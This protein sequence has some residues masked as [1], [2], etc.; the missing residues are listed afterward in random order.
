M[1]VLLINPP[2]TFY[3]G[4]EQPAGNLPIGLMYIAAVLQRA[5]VEVEILDAFIAGTFQKNGDAISVG[6]PFEQIKQEI[7]ARKPDIVGISGPFT[8]QIENSIKVSNLAKEVNP[9]I[10]TVMGGPHV[11]LVPKEFL[12]EAKN[13]DIAVIGEGEYAMLDIVQAFEGKKQLSRIQG[14]AYR[15]NEK[16]LVNPTRPL[17]EN[18]DDLPYPA[19]DLVN[20][21]QYLN[22]TKIGY[23]SFQDRAISM[24]TSRGCPF[25][26][27][28]CA[29]HLHMG[30]KF[31]AHSAKYVLDHIQYVVDKFKVK[32]IFFED[33]NLTLDV[34]RFEEICDGIIE[35][36][37]KI[38]W[39][40]PN[41]VRADCLNLELL[42]KMKQS[43]ANS[44]FVGVESG[45]Q[46]ILDNVICKSLDLNRVVEFA[47]DAQANRVKNRRLLHHRFPRRNKSEHAANRR[48][49]TSAKTR[50]RCG[51]APVYGNPVIWDTAL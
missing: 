27:C 48:F 18:L 13:V 45:D 14:I 7:I 40:T 21:E 20:M 36:K 28:F 43:G 29:V 2:Q 50:L 47:K 17:I 33:D 12:E 42:K 3:P 6:M 8:C 38:G 10:L 32:N 1:K 5:E 35:R 24:I 23:R 31:R 49:C 11:T 22:P 19:Y 34:K 15:Q 37:I 44:I 51:H 30:Q 25:N 26:C 39:E 9:K 16:V 46:Q 41:G 4:S